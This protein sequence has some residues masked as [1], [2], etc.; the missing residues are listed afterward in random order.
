MPILTDIMKFYALK[1]SEGDSFVL[2]TNDEKNYLIDTG[3]S[4]HECLHELRELAICRID[5]VFITH[6]DADHF[7]GLESVVNSSIDVRE[8]WLPDC[9]ARIRK[10]LHGEASKF[11]KTLLNEVDTTN[12]SAMVGLPTQNKNI[13]FTLVKLPDSV[14]IKRHLEKLS[15][16]VEICNCKNIP[17]RWLTY[18]NQICNSRILNNIIGLNCTENRNI[19]A[20]EDDLE[21]LYYLSRINQECIVIKYCSQSEV[22][23]TGDSGFSFAKDRKIELKDNS[24]VT[25]PH[26]GSRQNQLVYSIIQGSGLT[27]VRSHNSTVQRGSISETFIA[28]ERKYCVKCQNK[29]LERVFLEYIDGEWS[30]HNETCICTS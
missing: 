8:V 15:S 5:A 2:Q 24:I 6:F 26:H 14:L 3:K 1:I 28:L 12:A 21:V 23:L 17:V 25:A 27:Y 16:I 10:T 4:D 30:A 29:K 20:Y 7:N 19:Q 22:L 18:H 9:F 11:L 13:S